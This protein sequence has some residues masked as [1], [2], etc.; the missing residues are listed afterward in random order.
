MN[1]SIRSIIAKK[2]AEKKRIPDVQGVLF[3]K[4]YTTVFFLI[5]SDILFDGLI[6]FTVSTSA[7]CISNIVELIYSFTIDAQSKCQFICLFLL[8][9]IS[10]TS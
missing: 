5:A 10:P 9:T 4:F 6:D 1:R 8:Q 2:D 7:V 3:S